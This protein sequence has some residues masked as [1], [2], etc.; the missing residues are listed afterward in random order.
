MPEFPIDSIQNLVGLGWWE[1]DQ[2]RS[3]CRGALVWTWVQYFSNIPLQIVAERV[4]PMGHKIASLVA[5]P[6]HAGSRGAPDPALPVAGLPRLDGADCFLVNR[7]K[8][9]P[10][11]VLGGACQAAIDR[12]LVQGMSKSA[13]HIFVVVAPYYGVDQNVRAGYNPE[14]VEYIKHA[15]CRQFFWD[16]LPMGSQEESILRLDQVQPL[17]IHYQSFDHTGYRLSHN[18][19]EIMDEW[20][21]WF[22]HDIDGEELS[23]FRELI[24][25]FKNTC[26]DG[27]A[28]TD[29]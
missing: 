4:D 15:K 24:K 13:T 8:K 28:G 23:S 20:L 27:S 25:D 29:G 11:L 18:A 26:G 12:T 5:R 7:A 21:N 1:E 6:L 19:L 16:I 14:F 10:C 17:G 9:R 22:L 2:S 3:L